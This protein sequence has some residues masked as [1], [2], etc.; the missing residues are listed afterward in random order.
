MAE[1]LHM[2]EKRKR[3]IGILCSVPAFS[4]FITLVYYLVILSPLLHGHPQPAS[5]VG[6]TSAHYTILF[7]MLAASSVI[8]ACVL[9]FCVV[10]VAR[11][12][13]LNTAKKMIWILM[14][15]I[16]VPMSFL[17][18]WYFLIRHEPEWTAI[19]KDIA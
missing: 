19:N 8:S 4:F 2:D 13:S 10:H 14:L 1:L 12:Q 7:I 18:F 5:A 9:I 6:I 3:G 15:V 16:T 11:L 17:L